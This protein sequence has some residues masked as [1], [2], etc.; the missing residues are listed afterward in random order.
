MSKV[1]ILSLSVGLSFINILAILSMILIPIIDAGKNNSD[2]DKRLYNIELKK[3]LLK[4]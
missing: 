4:N 2:V 1:C 3:D